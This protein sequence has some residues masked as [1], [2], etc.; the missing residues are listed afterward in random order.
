MMMIA[1][2]KPT[3]DGDSTFLGRNGVSKFPSQTLTASTF[4]LFVPFV[5]GRYDF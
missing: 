3:W 4:V 5:D 2:E 1:F